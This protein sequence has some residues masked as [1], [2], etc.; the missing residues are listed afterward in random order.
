MIDKFFI[1]LTTA[2]MITAIW[3]TLQE[4]MIFG[5]LRPYLDKIESEYIRKPLYECLICMA[6][7][8]GLWMWFII[9]GGEITF[10]LVPYLLATCG[11]LTIISFCFGE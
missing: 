9:W 4:G 7:I 5:K 6:S 8:H 2:C 3:V 1:Y 11:I 10:D